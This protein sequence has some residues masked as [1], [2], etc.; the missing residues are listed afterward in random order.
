MFVAEMLDENDELQNFSEGV[1]K[2]VQ[3][4]S[5][6]LGCFESSNLKVVL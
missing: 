2:F 3:S 5:F 1:R 6:S 4:T